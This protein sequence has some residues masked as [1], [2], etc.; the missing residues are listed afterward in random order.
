MTRLATTK[1]NRFSLTRFLAA[2]R[3][4]REKLNAIKDISARVRTNVFQLTRECNLRCQ[5]CWYYEY[6]MDQGIEDRTD[7]GRIREIL[8]ERVADGITHALVVGGEPALYLNRLGVFAETMPYLSVATNGY[9]SI[10]VEGFQDVSIG[11]ALFAGY[12]SDD[13]YRA[14]RAGGQRFEGLFRR[15]LENYRGDD[16]V[17]VIYA[18]SEEAIDE[19]APTVD[20][21]EQNGNLVYFSYYR[22]YGTDDHAESDRATARLLERALEV[23]ARYPETVL[24]DP[25][26]IESLI[27]GK[28]SWGRFDYQSCATISRGL[29]DNQARL[30]SGGPVLPGFESFAQDLTTRRKCCASGDCGTCRDSLALSSWLLINFKEHVRD[31]VSLESWVNFAHGYWSGF[32]WSPLH[33]SKTRPTAKVTDP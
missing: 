21:I 20:M 22:H 6:K 15:G 13:R 8:G 5:G 1:D 4:L 28:T 9:R 31:A 11:L 3:D 32:A 10:P 7:L 26:Y 17:T 19:I 25:Y 14:I 30:K 18:L 12:R 33:R 16:R 29:P 2:R 23:R 24:A 27:L